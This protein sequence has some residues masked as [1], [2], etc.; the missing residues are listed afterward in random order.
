MTAAVQG[1]SVD[2]P[3]PDGAADAYMV[4]PDDGAPHPG[5]LLYMDG[6]GLR[7]SLRTMADHIA[8]HGYTVLAPNVFY[9]HGRAPVV[10]LPDF[11][12]PAQRPEIFQQLV[13]MIVELTP[14]LVARDAGAY[15]GWLA[16]FSRTA[17]GPVGVTGYCMGGALALRAAAAFPDWVAA[18]AGFHGGPLVTDAADSP[19]L[20]VGTITAELYYGHAGADVKQY[21][22]QFDR[23]EKALEAAGVRYTCEVYEGAQHGYTQA[24]TAAYD[25]A[26]T[27]HHWRELLALFDRTLQPGRN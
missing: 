13:P 21:P 22:E 1:I 10:K 4:Y 24:D 27:E 7:P 19:H 11:I 20:S 2:I 14:D 18:A 16:G 12:D 25:A 26:A 6:F 17:D 3:T 8:A 5:V 15:L 9:R 23:F